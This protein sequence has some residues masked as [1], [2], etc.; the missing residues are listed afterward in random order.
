MIDPSALCSVMFKLFVL[1]DHN[2]FWS[3]KNWLILYSELKRF[4]I[5]FNWL[6]KKE[7]WIRLLQTYA[8][9]WWWK[10]KPNKFTEWFELI[11]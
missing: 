7:F 10:K 5:A 2:V 6:S 3:E 8:F 9:Q 11:F 4:L 1:N